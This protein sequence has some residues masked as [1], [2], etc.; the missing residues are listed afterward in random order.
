ME[1]RTQVD[2]L[3]REALVQQVP[4]ADKSQN[5]VQSAPGDRKAGEPGGGDLVVDAFRGIRGVEPYDPGVR[6]HERAHLPLVQPEDAIDHGLFAR[7]ERSAQRPLPDQQ[8]DLFWRDRRFCRG[9][10]A[11]QPDDEVR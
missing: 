4:G 3:A 1:R 9:L 11:E 7:L 8:L 5:V 2:G 6:R 10:D